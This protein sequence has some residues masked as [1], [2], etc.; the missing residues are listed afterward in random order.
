[1]FYYVID[2]SEK[3]WHEPNKFDPSR[4][5]ERH[6]DTLLPFGV[7]SHSCI[8]QNFAM[9]EAK[10]MLALIVRRFHFELVP[11]QKHVPDIAVTIRLIILYYKI[12]CYVVCNISLDLSMAC[13]CEFRHVIELFSCTIFQIKIRVLFF[14][15]SLSYT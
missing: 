15:Q 1:M 12:F 13:G 2:R 10:I 5:N 8:G 11:G 6:L 14:R 4:F 3:Y 9:L 7:G